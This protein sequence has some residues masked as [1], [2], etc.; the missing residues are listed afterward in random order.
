MN[1]DLPWNPRRVEQRI[2]RF[3]WIGQRYPVVE[4]LNFFDAGT[5]EAEIYQRL[6][7]RID[8]FLRAHSASTPVRQPINRGV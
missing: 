8:W 3:D 7:H 2:G 6:R 5:I 1:D 4:V